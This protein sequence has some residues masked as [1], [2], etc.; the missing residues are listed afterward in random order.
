MGLCLELH[1]YP[2]HQ[3]RCGLL[4]LRSDLTCVCAHTGT[5][6]AWPP[7]QTQAAAR[8]IKLQVWLVCQIEVPVGTNWHK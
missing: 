8:C 3:V 6:T 2:Q 4:W 5:H 1:L 7:T